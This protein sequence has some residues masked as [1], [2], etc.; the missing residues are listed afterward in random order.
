M[1]FMKR[2]RG[3]TQISSKDGG[4]KTR[5]SSKDSGKKC[6][7][8]QRIVVKMWISV[9]KF[10]DPRVSYLAFFLLTFAFIFK[11]ICMLTYIIPV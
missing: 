11:S 3:K 7:I 8:H 9:R 4:K 6:K 10:K 2:L 5:I 1:N